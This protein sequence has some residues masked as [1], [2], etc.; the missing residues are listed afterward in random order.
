MKSLKQSKDGVSIFAIRLFG[1]CFGVGFKRRS[2]DYKT[3][4]QLTEDVKRADSDKNFWVGRSDELAKM[5]DGLLIVTTKDKE[6][7]ALM[8][9]TNMNLLKELKGYR[10]LSNCHN[11]VGPY[12]PTVYIGVDLAADGTLTFDGNKDKAFHYLGCNS[13]NKII[14]TTLICK[15][16]N[17]VFTYNQAID[18][19]LHY[20]TECQ[21]CDNKGSY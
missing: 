15:K 10:M 14:A 21:Y 11:Y 6:K 2:K 3:R 12:G 20:G 5:Y 17:S 7:M 16:C 8:A 18:M 13:D 9:Q 1:Y 19:I 4:E